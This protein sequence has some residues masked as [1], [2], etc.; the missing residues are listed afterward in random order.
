MTDEYFHYRGTR[1]TLKSGRFHERGTGRDMFEGA[2][3]SR[4]IDD[5][6]FVEYAS[7]FLRK[8]R[9]FT[10]ENPS[11]SAV[12]FELSLGIQRGE[13]AVVESHITLWSIIPASF[14]ALSR[15]SPGN[16]SG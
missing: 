10:G 16:I 8:D 14:R 1:Y 12:M 11:A 6:N 7:E 3:Y 13:I 9:H 2:N 5:K 15:A 4:W